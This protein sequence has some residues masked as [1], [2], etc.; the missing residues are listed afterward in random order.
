LNSSLWRR[1]PPNEEYT[2][3][4]R[5]R[6]LLVT[7]E[8][9][10]VSDVSAA[11]A[12][13]GR[14]ELAPPCRFLADLSGR[15]ERA[16]VPAVLVDIDADPARAFE[17]LAP[18]V[19]RFVETRFIVLSSTLRNGLVLEA[20]QIGARHFLIK[21]SIRAELLPVL[22][23]LLPDRLSDRPAHGV[24]TTVL[25]A[26]GGCGA[27]TVAFN[28][29]N[30]IGLETAEPVLLIDLDCCY[31][32]A[33]PYLGLEAEYGI[34]DVLA[35]DGEI[36]GH[37][38]RSS[39]VAYSDQVHV[40]LSPTSINFSQPKPLRHESLAAVVAACKRSYRHTVIDAP[41]VSMDLAADLAKA[42]R[43]TLIMFQLMVK[44]IHGARSI[45]SALA[46]RGV[47]QD[48]V[49]P[50]VSRHGK[51][52]PVSLKET[53]KALGGAKLRTVRNDFRSTLRSITY[54]EPLAKAAASSRLRRDIRQLA[55]D[56]ALNK[57]SRS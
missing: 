25:S 9:E 36:D 16:Q 21:R 55:L 43:A 50:L 6:L 28:L 44:D 11:L 12:L 57:G 37:L 19:A 39:T 42:S 23:R 26:G 51:R 29:A 40:L 4:D 27:T 54:G 56:I 52:N 15:L 46:E 31:G 38:I 47:P 48:R 3:A 7:S 20:M 1:R 34:A 41:R 35:Y 18:I 33:A 14:F 30:E 10:T 8:S 5:E 45:R 53:E 32:A 22:H 49:V 13:N 24:L 2:V 17:G